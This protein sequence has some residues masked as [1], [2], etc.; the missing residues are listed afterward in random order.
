MTKVAFN[1]GRRTMPEWTTNKDLIQKLY[2]MFY[3]RPADPGGLK[4]W[5]EQLPENARI[6]SPEVRAMISRFINSEEAQARFGNPAT[7][8]TITRLILY[9]FQRDATDKDM[10]ALKDKP[11]EEVIIS[12]LNPPSK[13]DVI[14]LEKKVTYANAF[15]RMLDPNEDGIPNDGKGGSGFVATYSG[16]RDAEM[17]ASKIFLVDEKADLD[18]MSIFNDIREAI[19]RPTDLIV[20]ADTPED[21]KP[22]A[23][24]KV[25]EKIEFD[26]VKVDVLTKV[27]ERVD[28]IAEI[29][30]VIEKLNQIEDANKLKT[31][32]EAIEKSPGI[33]TVS[34]VLSKVDEVM[35][36]PTTPTT[37]PTPPSPPGPVDTGGAPVDT[38]GAPVDTGGAPVDTTPPTITGTTGPSS[39]WYRSG[40]H[41]EFKVTFSEAVTVQGTPRLV[42]TIGNSTKYATYQSGS[43]TNELTFRYQIESN[44]ED[45]DGITLNNS[46][47]LNNGSIKDA[48]GNTLA[49]TSFTVPNLSGVKVD[50]KVPAAPSSLDLVAEDDTGVSNSDK[51]TKK[52]SDLTITGNAEAGST[53][54]LY[55]GETLLGS[56]SAGNDGK[57]SIDIT[58]SEGIHQ[59]VA[60]AIDEAGNV[61]E[62]SGAL[63]ITVDTTAPGKAQANEIV[64]ID[65]NS[66]S[67]YNQGDKIKI[68]FSE[69]VKVENISKDNITVSNNHSLGEGV[70][71]QAKDS[72]N[73]YATTFEI[74]LGTGLTVAKDDTLTIDKSNVED[75]AG[76]T[77]SSDVVFTVP[78]PKA[79]GLNM[80][81]MTPG[82][83]IITFGENLA[84][85]ISTTG[86]EI[87]EKTNSG[88]QK[89]DLPNSFGVN[90]KTATLNITFSNNFEW[91]LFK[92][93]GELGEIRNADSSKYLD[94]INAV[95]G[96]PNG[97]T[98]DLTAAGA[99]NNF[100]TN[101]QTIIFG[102]NGA[103][104]IKLSGGNLSSM[105][106]PLIIYGGQ[107]DDTF[108]ISNVT[109]PIIQDVSGSD[110][111]IIGS[112]VVHAQIYINGNWTAPEGTKTDSAFMD[113]YGFVVI[114]KQDN[115]SNKYNIDLT[116]AGSGSKGWSINIGRPDSQI[117]GSPKD[118][119]ISIPFRGDDNAASIDGG[120]G[121]DSIGVYFWSYNQSG[122]PEVKLDNLDGGDGTK[123]KLILKDYGTNDLP[124]NLSFDL[125]QTD[126]WKITYNGNDV[127][128][129]NSGITVKGF[130]YLS[131]EN[132]G[133]FDG[134]TIT[135]KGPLFLVATEET[136]IINSAADGSGEF[137]IRPYKGSDTINL[138]Q[139]TSSIDKIAFEGI[140]WVNG[141]DTINGFATNDRLNFALFLGA[142]ENLGDKV[143]DADSQADGIQHVNALSNAGV[144][145]SGKVVIVNG[146]HNDLDEASE[147]AGLFGSD[148]ALSI[149]SG[150]KAVVI[151]T[152]NDSN[153]F[154]VWFVHDMDN[155]GSI[156]ASE[157]EVG[158]VGLVTLGNSLTY[159]SGEGKFMFSLSNFCFADILQF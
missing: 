69:P 32:G 42:L 128:G 50:S 47:D 158:L 72:N 23:D 40:D 96:N 24:A 95:A 147:I 80:T 101:W 61:S 53:V 27:V 122:N 108:E 146:S 9:A 14:A 156:A 13:G 45:T 85:N 103:D 113:D 142:S 75:R 17:M 66:D 99:L 135:G 140:A 87:Y 82:S 116:N 4:Y 67:S 134:V 21:I 15:V 91:V 107:G 98:I 127:A 114:S 112:Q 39:G 51:I 60:K 157:G 131:L 70:T 25:S 56:G 28:D 120:A 105:D 125:T 8:Y 104:T 2:I 88:L 124:G 121:D 35:T 5:A 137:A 151:T 123:D 78:Q 102:G 65:V 81:G 90:N 18:V 34:E 43:G 11:V 92:Y 130:E 16:V 63:T 111:V 59:I 110:K 73:G 41:L 154:R 54:K 143:Y 71:I 55:E 119:Y 37:P 79:F 68:S 20:T 109:W 115:D 118:D 84:S 97:A 1:S 86:L 19:G 150:S 132:L 152:E 83:L 117:I 149:S 22:L 58:L 129:G 31:V 145:V 29:G 77:P 46:L 74:T 3:G 52:T 148:K 10:N 94:S 57:F 126:S 144:N 38:G 100:N 159:G 89:L 6:D 141:V 93:D 153:T 48:A 33:D 106:R 133:V 30:K 155:N 138:T 36:A 64:G 62:A 49:N 136:D 26:L 12:L 44:L 76:N 7:H 139:S